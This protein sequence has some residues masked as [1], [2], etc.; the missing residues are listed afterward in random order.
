M[1]FGHHTNAYTGFEETVYQLEL[2]RGTRQMLK[3]GLLVFRDYLSGLSLESK[4]LNR[5]RGVILSEFRHT[6]SPQY[7]DLQANYNFLFAG[8]AIG[9]RFPIGTEKVVSDITAED[10][11][12]FYKKFYTPNASAV[13]IVGDVDPQMAIKC[14]Q[15]IMGDIPEGRGSRPTDTGKIKA[16]GV[17]AAV[18][19]DEEL[20]QVTVSINAVEPLSGV[21]DSKKLRQRDLYDRVGNSVLTRR[22]ERL[23]KLPKASFYTGESS[24]SYGMRNGVRITSLALTA[25]GERALEAMRTAERTLRM[26][27]E[28]EFSTVEVENAKASVLKRYADERDRAKS[29]RSNQLANK[30]INAIGNNRVPTSPE[31][32]YEFAKEVIGGMAAHDVWLAYREGWAPKNRLLYASGNLPRTVGEASLRTAYTKSQREFSRFEQPVVAEVFAYDDFG[33]PGKIV[34]DSYDK[35]LG[36]HCYTFE[37]GVRL[38]IKPTDFET[39]QVL[40]RVRFGRGLLT[41]PRKQEGLSKFAAWS[42]VDGGLGRHSCDDLQDIFSGKT[43]GVHFGVGVDASLLSGRTTRDDL[44]D[45]LRLLAAYIVDPAFSEVGAQEA[46][47]VIAQVYPE[48]EHTAEGVLGD[49]GQQFLHNNDLR[50]GYP[51]QEVMAAYTMD[52][53]REWLAEELRDGYM[54]IT[55]VGDVDVDHTLDQVHRIFGALKMRSGKPATTDVPLEMPVGEVADFTF[56]T[57]IPKG[58]VQYMWPTGDTWD[59]VRKR[60]LDLLADL[61][62]ERARVKIRKELGDSYAPNAGNFASL[63]FADYGYIYVNA[64]VDVAKVDQTADVIREIADELAKHEISDDEFWRVKGPALTEVRELLRKNSYWLSALDGIQA[65]PAKRDFIKTFAYFYENVQRQDLQD[66]LKYLDNSKRMLIKIRPQ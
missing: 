36:L 38:N 7:R 24:T 27:M 57:A 47:K 22:L 18:Y 45:E 55:I 35:D 1:Q 19:R 40:V 43:W 37:N 53:V 59:I 46:Q 49:E 28:S 44:D 20:P 25:D 41:E 32:D 14:L 60:K 4:E 21:R 30:W 63:T 58:L 51:D 61:L 54:E 29:R 8:S 2:P 64:L 33:T 31:W 62:Q 56:E 65:Y 15:H 17:R 42:F 39:G 11:C 12:D 13:V 5:E 52:D 6:D 50:F 10:M 9:K 3:D 48:M 34:L 16:S 23:S 66:V 26:A